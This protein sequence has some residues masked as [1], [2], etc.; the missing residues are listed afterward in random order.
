M[1]VIGA[2]ALDRAARGTRLDGAST[3][4]LGAAAAVSDRRERLADL[5]AR[6]AISCL[7]V[8]LA[9]RIGREFL[10]TG[11]FTGL[12][13]LLSEALVV[14]L[15][16]VRRRAAV[17]DRS[18]GARVVATV[19][20]VGVPFI[21]PSGGGLTA[22]SLTAS[23]SAAGLL[24]IIVGK[25]TLGR[26]FGLMPANR[27]VVDHGIYALLR[28]PIYAGYLVTHVA[29]LLAHPSAW[30]LAVLTVSDVALMVRALYEERTLAQD[31]A[32]AAYMTRVR[33]RVCPG[34][35]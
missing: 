15:T 1:A 34:I 28:H 26:S 23:L 16:V 33:Y 3:G 4:Q 21:V 20:I 8:I 7:F 27:G 18:W 10:E 6:A 13:L 5:F 24:L 22:D 17:V 14:L 12:L 35:F 31:P 32:Y 19:S 9:V 30:N 25:A 11:H 2:S 29:F